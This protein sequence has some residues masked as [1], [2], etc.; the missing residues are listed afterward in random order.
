MAGGT[1]YTYGVDESLPTL[2]IVG[3][4]RLCR[5]TEAERLAADP[6]QV[7]LKDCE[8]RGS[9]FDPRDIPQS[10]PQVAEGSIANDCTHHIDQGA[11][12]YRSA[13]A[14][15]LACQTHNSADTC[16]DWHGCSDG[17]QTCSGCHFG[18]A[19]TNPNHSQ[20][21]LFGC[22][23]FQT[24]NCVYD[25]TNSD[26]SFSKALRIFAQCSGAT[27]EAGYCRGSLASAAFLANHDVCEG[28]STSNIGFRAPPLRL[29]CSLTMS[30]PDSVL[31][32][33]H[34]HPV[35]REQPGCPRLPL[36]HG[37]RFGLVHRRRRA[38][39]HLYERNCLDLVSASA[40]R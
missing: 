21:L 37:L 3:G 11:I 2:P 38:G 26:G 19:Q 7:D 18:C 5:A 23:D 16:D 14:G 40:S 27:Q 4:Y 15:R 6:P 32:R 34:P 12:C 10:T 36:P 20:D 13:D 35:L 30:C 1:L 33:R 28:G 24:T 8:E 39:A 29:Y 22:V 31:L 17:C 25:V 9:P